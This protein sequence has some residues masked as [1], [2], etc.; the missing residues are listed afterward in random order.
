[1]NKQIVSAVKGT[2]DFYPEDMA[3]RNWLYGKIREVSEKFGYQE[4]DGPALE[5]LDLYAEK[6]S[7]EILSE[8]TFTIK[9]KSE[10]PM[11][12]RPELTPTFARMVAQKSQEL[13][14]PIRWFAFSKVWRYEQPQKGRLREFFQWEINL[15]GPENPEA[16]A[17][18]LAIAVEYFKVLGLTAK[19]IVIRVNDREWMQSQLK[20]IGT[21]EKQLCPVLRLVDRKEKITTDEFRL[22]LL[23]IGLSKEQVE[24]VELILTEKDYS[25]S[26]WLQKV[27]KSLK[28]YPNILDFIEFDPTIVRGFDYYT[29]TVFEAWERDGNLKRSIF[30]GGRFDNLTS[31][32]G[33]EKIP[34]VGFAIG[35]VPSQIILEQYNRMPKISPKVAQVLVTVFN[36]DLYPKSLEVS[37]YLRSNNINTEL[38]L[39]SDTKLDKQLKYADQKGIPY[40]IIIGPDEAKN[41]QVTLKN[42]KEKTQET[43]N[44]DQII[45]TI[46][47]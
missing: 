17:E 34:G 21:S 12:L 29:R 43:L 22:S 40:V 39:E 14:K 2:R 18:I 15:L 1:M 30:G 44:I 35:D 45:A 4:F 33:G 6:S 37:S 38:W 27:F 36:A 24:K 7:R 10:N 16:D 26:P 8:Q 42:L 11:I 47:G 25:K 28:L 19:E 20:E 9:T 5:Y 32:V 31:Q 3:F 13:L 41:D 23:E 46:K